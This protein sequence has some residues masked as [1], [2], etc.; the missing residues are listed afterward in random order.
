MILLTEKQSRSLSRLLLSVADDE[1]MMGHRG[2][3][4]L[5]LG[6]DLEE[7]L[8]ISSISQ[9][10]IGHAALFYEIAEDLGQPCGDIEVYFRDPD[11]WLCATLTILPQQDWAEWVVRRYLYETFDSI[12]RTALAAIPYPPLE[13]A[14]QKIEREEAYHITHSETLMRILAEGGSVSAG[15]LHAAV[16]RDWRYVDSLFHRH[17]AE[18][19]SSPWTQPGLSA[20]HMKRE[21]E[22]RILHQFTL[23]GISWPV[24]DPEIRE[25]PTERL[26]YLEPIVQETREV[27]RMA[28]TSEW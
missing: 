17:F 4:W 2:G 7:D 25:R 1:W 28:P 12:R 8:A 13:Y 19:S 11:E 9:D 26:Q 24:N 6:P 10:E 3:E 5:A 23:W 27:R 22:S 18:P 16:V 21:F 15:Y 20:E 14:L